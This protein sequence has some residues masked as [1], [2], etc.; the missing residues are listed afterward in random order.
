MLIMS[1][2]L[3]KDFDEW[4]SEPVRLSTESLESLQKTFERDLDRE[5]K[6]KEMKAMKQYKHA[7]TVKLLPLSTPMKESLVDQYQMICDRPMLW[8]EL[9]KPSRLTINGLCSQFVSIQKAKIKDENNTNPVQ[10]VLYL[11][12]IM[13]SIRFYFN[14][15]LEINVLFRSEKI[16]K[17]LLERKLRKSLNVEG[18]KDIDWCGVYGA[19]HLFRLLFHLEDIYNNIKKWESPMQPAKISNYVTLF[20]GFL[21]KEFREIAVNFDINENPKG[22]GLVEQF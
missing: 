8:I 17:T 15:Y 16:Q 12:Q 5:K 2:C 14:S 21:T 13:A 20:Q 4:V 9:P 18:A 6:K 1:L 11:K 7:D 22:N 10:E 3:Y 19:E